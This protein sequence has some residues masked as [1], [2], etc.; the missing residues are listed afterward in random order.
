MSA[1]EC[2]P[3]SSLSTHPSALIPRHSFLIPATI[4]AYQSALVSGTPLTP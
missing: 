2:V 3:Y 4:H 1:E